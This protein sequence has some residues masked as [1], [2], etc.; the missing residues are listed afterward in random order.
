MAAGSIIIDLLM[1]TGSFETDTKR[2]EAN[3]RRMTKTAKDSSKGIRDS[4][5]GNLLA[6]FVGG[7]I[8]DIGRV[9]GAVIN[10]VD[11]LNDVKD[12]TGASIENLS[13]LEDIGARTGTSFDTI[14]SGLVKFN[15][16]LKDADPDNPVA[17]ALKRIGLN[18]AELRK[19]DPAEALLE[20]SKSMQKYAADG[21]RARLMQDIFGKSTREVAAFMKDLAEKGKLVA[22]VTT[23]Q[24]EEA[25]A[26]NKELFAMQKNVADLSRGFMMDLVT[27]INA[28]AKA[29]REGGLIEG[30]RALFGGTEQ[31]KSDKR[32]VELTNDLLIAQ[33]NLS[34]AK[35]LHE[36][37]W[38]L[39]TGKS[40]AFW[41][42][43]VKRLDD[44]TKA[45]LAARNAPMPFDQLRAGEKNVPSLLPSVGPAPVPTKKGPKGPDP[46]ADF[47]AY[48]EN[49]QK[50]I[51]ATR[52]LGVSEKLLDD[53][54]RGALTV[55]PEQKQQLENLAKQ[56]EGEESA[57]DVAKER[58]RIR[59]EEYAAAE[60]LNE[61]DVEW[62]K[63]LTDDTP[64]KNMEK[65]TANLERLD[66][67]LEQGL[68]DPKVWEEAR[69]QLQGLTA[70][71]TKFVDDFTLALSETE[72][73]L[74]SLGEIGTS[75]LRDM[76]V[77]GKDFGDVIKDV[78]LQI[79]DLIFQLLVVKPLMDAI[80]GAMG[81]GGVPANP[82]YS[83]WGTLFNSVMSY[84]GAKAGGGYVQAGRSYDVGEFGPERFTPTTAGVITPT[85]GASGRGVTI[86]QRDWKFGDVASMTQVRKEISMANQSL[87]A[88]VQRDRTY[89][90]GR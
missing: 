72:E 11:A 74:L 49:L 42:G 30:M 62:L 53:I 70:D 41:E 57:M 23:E 64:T 69:Q 7:M 65:L 14:T 60:K 43:E 84:G 32:F 39:G 8:R 46:D 19:M 87:I 33:N 47:K 29:L 12:A 28:A 55:S 45:L 67:A 40:V 24:A 34:K 17:Q 77:G 82:D 2:A 50:Q 38:V 4:F 9:P 71:N 35:E 63:T 21:D 88:G 76:V 90:R 51:Q 1:R 73:A 80:K 85:G 15:M 27:G 52:D 26:F 78:G 6:D 59:T 25:E 20:V 83:I 54:R 3:L 81:M 61:A 13:A 79:A 68:I 37:P 31:F 18:A 5:T 44:A 75:A 22:T 10:A 86:I 56:I 48:L 36:K 58:Q 16:G 66:R 89:G